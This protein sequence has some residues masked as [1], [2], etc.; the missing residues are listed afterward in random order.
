MKIGKKDN[1]KVWVSIGFLLFLVVFFLAIFLL[2]KQK[3]VTIVSF[4]DVGQGDSI[5]IEAPNGNQVLIDAGPNAGV[6]QELSKVIPFW[7]R[8]IDMI[9]PTH[10]DKDHIAGFPEVLKRY[11]V[12]SI[13]DTS[14]Q[15]T[16]AIYGEYTARRDEE[17]S[18]IRIASSLDTIVLDSKEH[19]YLRVLYPDPGMEEQNLERNDNSTIIQLVYGDIQVMLTGDVGVMVENYLV[20]KYGGFLE[21]EILKAGHHGS[22]TSS[23][24]LFLQTVNP[25]YVVVS[26]GENNQ[27]GHP[28]Q[29]VIQE[30]QTIGAQMLETSKEGTISFVIDGTNIWRKK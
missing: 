13:Y 10:A 24:P 26:A 15:A 1:L 8:T 9:I 22:K 5:F 12:Q 21:S 6:I 16:T 18:P 28:H 25:S 17:K 29:E 7:D 4:L 14:N 2:G 23:S 30:I 27:Y 20:Y 11:K 3:P 19:V